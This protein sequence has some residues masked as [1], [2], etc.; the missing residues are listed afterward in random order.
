MESK[1]DIRELK[2]RLSEHLGRVRAGESLIVTEHG[3]PIARIIPIGSSV[4]S[5]LREMVAAGIVEWNGAKPP[6]YQP[7]AANRGPGLLSDLVLQDRV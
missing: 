4:E 3:T 7:E 1:I 5:R 2:S 6:S